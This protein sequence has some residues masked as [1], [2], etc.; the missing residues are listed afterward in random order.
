MSIRLDARAGTDDDGRFDL[1]DDRRPRQA[2]AGT[3]RIAVVD[4]AV[5]EAAGVGVVDL[6]PPLERGARALA[7]GEGLQLDVGPG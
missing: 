5:D 7:G 3:E 6:A 1:L 4:R 2:H